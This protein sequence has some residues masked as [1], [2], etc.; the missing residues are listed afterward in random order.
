MASLPHPDQLAFLSEEEL[1]ALAL[2]LGVQTQV[3]STGTAGP[4]LAGAPPRVKHA[5]ATYNQIAQM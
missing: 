1:L 3:K 4:N 5:I 2:E